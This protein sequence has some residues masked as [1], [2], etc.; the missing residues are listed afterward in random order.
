MLSTLTSCAYPC[1]LSPCTQRLARLRVGPI[2]KEGSIVITSRNTLRFS[3]DRGASSVRLW[4]ANDLVVDGCRLR[5]PLDTRADDS[6]SRLHDVTFHR[7]NRTAPWQLTTDADAALE[8][9][10]RYG[11]LLSILTTPGPLVLIVPA[12]ALHHL[13]IATRIAHD[14]WVYG[15][16]DA[17]IITDEQAKAEMRDERQH[18]GLQGNWIV[19]GGRENAMTGLLQSTPREL[20][21]LVIQ[22]HQTD[23]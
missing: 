21:S 18:E 6:S 9:I 17:R 13:Q 10:R 23:G 15:R 2:N 20:T 8:P 22:P 19:V 11:P 4:K 5:L 12:R 7:V 14:A 16:F 3:L 1:N